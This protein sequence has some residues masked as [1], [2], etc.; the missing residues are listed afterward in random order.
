M[1]TSWDDREIAE[2][3]AKVAAVAAALPGVEQ[4]EA[5]GHTIYALKGR[6]FAYLEV[7][8]HGDGR[9]ALVL[10]AQPGEQRALVAADPGRYF[11]PAYLGARGWVGAALDA[12]SEPD[13]D[14]VGGL[15][16]EAW[17]LTAGKRA[18]A[19]MDAAREGR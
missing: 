4:E 1:G 18:I 12:A 2:V 15:L 19:R 8:H 5:N 13:W 17:R 6:R 3:Q 11:V 16:E 10:K 14:E 7:D 9:L